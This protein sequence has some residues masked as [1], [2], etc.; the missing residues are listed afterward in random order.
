LLGN[1]HKINKQISAADGVRHQ[2]RQTDVSHNVT[3]TLRRMPSR[4]TKKTVQKLRNFH[5]PKRYECTTD[6][7]I[8]SVF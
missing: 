2:D 8:M 1:E 7:N 3:L 4:T 6:W 5:R